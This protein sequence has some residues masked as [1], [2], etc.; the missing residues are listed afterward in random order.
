MNDSFGS[1][2]TMTVAD[3]PYRIRRLSALAG[4]GD[5]GRLPY[6]VKVLL[7]NV[8]RHEDGETVTAADI[9]ALAK[10]PAGS[11]TSRELPFRPERVLMQDFTGVP[12]VVDLIALRDAATRRAAMWPGSIPR[13]PWSSSSITR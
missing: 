6:C 3:R 11:D 9:E 12:A 5:I 10:W 2:A 13:F 1:R 8:L 7:E 4:L